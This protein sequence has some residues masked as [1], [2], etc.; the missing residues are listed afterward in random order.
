MMRCTTL[1]PCAAEN[2]TVV[3][4]LEFVAFDGVNGS[5]FR[6]VAEN[7]GWAS[8]ESEL[9]TIIIGGE[10]ERDTYLFSKT[11]MVGHQYF[12]LSPPSPPLILAP[13]PPLFP[14]P[15]TGVP[16]PP[17]PTVDTITSRTALVSWPPPFSILPVTQYI[18]TWIRVDTGERDSTTIDA[19]MTQLLLTDLRPN[20]MYSVTVV[21]VNRV[22][23]SLPPD[24]VVFTTA[25]DGKSEFW[26]HAS[27][28]VLRVIQ[29][30]DCDSCIQVTLLPHPVQHQ[31][32]PQPTSP[33]PR[34][35]VM[36]LTSPGILLPWSFKMGL[37][38]TTMSA[39]W[40]REEP[41][42][43]SV[44]PSS[45]TSTTLTMGISPGT[46]YLIRVAAA[47]AV[48]LGPFSGNLRQMTLSEPPSIPP[49]PS[50]PTNVPVTTTTIS[51]TLPTVTNLQ[52]FRYSFGVYW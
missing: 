14:L 6:C 30:H 33:P 23:P 26:V 24:P 39:M 32:H 20:W 28:F 50:P 19:D 31:R 16:L 8:T 12:S 15:L 11:S 22:G 48:G 18:I 49:P 45:F 38:L 1:R 7:R 2:G 34:P 29:K 51:I 13:L 36:R 37:S 10:M 46:A 44:F 52:E 4:V 35:N 43:N 25:E 47:T 21:S 17:N 40:L 27:L 9:A 5:Q 42:Q 3:S 41:R